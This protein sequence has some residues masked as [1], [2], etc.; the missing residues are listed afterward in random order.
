MAAAA[1][2][3]TRRHSVTVAMAAE[4][5]LDSPAPGRPAL[6]QG[7]SIHHLYATTAVTTTVVADAQRRS[8]EK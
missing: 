5:F 7:R 8:G 6:C 2:D 1:A 4:V 3:T